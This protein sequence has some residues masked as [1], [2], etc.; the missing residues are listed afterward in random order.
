MLN[1]PEHLKKNNQSKKV[2]ILPLE[3]QQASLV[4][5]GR[6]NSVGKLDSIFALLPF[7]NRTQTQPTMMCVCVCTIH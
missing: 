2:K 5:D 1:T 4:S 6:L 7:L 3:I